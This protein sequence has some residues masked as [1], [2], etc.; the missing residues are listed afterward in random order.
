MTGLLAWVALSRTAAFAWVDVETLCSRTLRYFQQG[1]VQST[2]D[3]SGGSA[4]GPSRDPRFS[5]GRRFVLGV[6]LSCWTARSPSSCFHGWGHSCSASC[7][8]DP[9]RSGKYRASAD[10][11]SGKGVGLPR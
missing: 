5:W 7:K 6:S 11:A 8:P 1:R 3:F 9:R 4:S 2:C 10:L